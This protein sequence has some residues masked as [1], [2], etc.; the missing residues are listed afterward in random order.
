[1][2]HSRL[3]HF[4]CASVLVLVACLLS[5]ASCESSEETPQAETEYRSK[6]KHSHEEPSFKRHPWSAADV[7]SL[8]DTFWYVPATYLKAYLYVNGAQLPVLDQ[9]VWHLQTAR[10]PD[11][12]I[13]GKS[14]VSFFPANPPAGF[15]PSYQ[16]NRMMGSITPSSS[17]YISFIP[18]NNLNG[19]SVTTGLGTFG[20]FKQNW[21]FEM[22]MG[23]GSPD[24]LAA[25][26][27]YMVPCA[28]D[29]PCFDSLP[30]VG[31]SIPEFMSQCG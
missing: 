1:M 6:L 8:D 25:H 11:R 31:M 17:V 21:A 18:A 28:R 13:F 22:Q 24:V 2:A 3:L 9:T 5:S 4:W 10:T 23:S 12:Y 19:T 29:E 27:A 14:V 20:S 30:G 26:W 15:Q 16:C 7:A